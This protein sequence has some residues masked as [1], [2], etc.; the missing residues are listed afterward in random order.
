VRDEEG[1]QMSPAGTIEL[2]Q[3]PF[4]ASG[5]PA[6]ALMEE[7]D[8]IT[9]ATGD[10]PMVSTSL[11]LAAWRGQEARALELIGASIQDATSRGQ[12][13]AISLAGYARA[14]LYNGLARYEDART[15]A[16]QACD[17]NGRLSTWAL[18]ELVEASARSGSRDV[19]AAALQRLEKR[20][21]AGGAG[22]AL[23]IQTRSRALV[24][25]RENAEALYRGAIEQLAASRLTLHFARARL[26]YGEWLR[27]EARRVDAREQLRIALGLFDRMGAH[28]FGERARRE[29]LATVAK[30][31]KRSVETR[32]DLTAQESQIAQLAGAGFTNPEIGSRLFIS[33]RT[34]EWHLRKVFPKLGISSRQQLRDALPDPRGGGATPARGGRPRQPDE[35]TTSL[36]SA[37]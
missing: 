37:M 34:V 8:A 30:A 3:P 35:T 26:L 10:A 29:L 19:G 1:V 21:S 18:P 36:T 6:A 32:D 27:R 9:G 15:A 11:V 16:E 7:A 2:A 20:T 24:S 31:R 12:A 33:P 22:W 23:G 17:K 13:S 5:S 14:V 4:D 25:E 28:G